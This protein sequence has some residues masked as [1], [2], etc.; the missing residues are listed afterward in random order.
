MHNYHLGNSRALAPRDISVEVW[1][2]GSSESYRRKRKKEK[3]NNKGTNKKQDP[4]HLQL[5]YSPHQS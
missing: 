1:L 4:Q 5:R 3:K 2:G